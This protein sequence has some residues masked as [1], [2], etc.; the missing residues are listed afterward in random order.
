[1]LDLLVMKNIFYLFLLSIFL[2]TGCNSEDGD[3]PE[4]KFNSAQIREITIE[5]I[6]GNEDKNNLLSGVIDLSLPVNQNYN[7][8]LIDSLMAGKKKFYSLLLEFSNPIYNCFAIYDEYLKCYLID[9]SING[10]IST[11]NFT[12]GDHNFISLIENFLTKDTVEIQR[13]SI[14]RIKED[15]VETVFKTFTK[16]IFPKEEISQEIKT[17]SD[18]FISTLIRQPILGTNPVLPDTFFYDQKQKKYISRQSTFESIIL[19]KIND[20]NSS[21]KKKS[22]NRFEDIELLRTELSNT[23]F[24]HNNNELKDYSIDIDSTW[25]EINNFSITQNLKKEI[26][27]TRY[28]N[29]RLGTTISVAKINATDSAESYFN[30]P[31]PNKTTGEYYVRFSNAFEQGKSILLFVEHSCKNKKYIIILEAP[32]FTYAKYKS[33]YENILNS[34]FIEC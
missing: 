29:N 10:F 12:V 28:V 24:Q 27:G 7:K 13:V 23:S 32:K 19:E 6:K 15:S 25:Q 8:L 22:I 2:I 31:L 11:N 17:I 5:A 30:Q 26:K 16:A 34:F 9:K 1:M 14:Y 3:K 33:L 20:Y 21:A 4:T 18:N